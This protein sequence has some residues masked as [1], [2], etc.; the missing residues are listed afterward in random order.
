[1]C[2]HISYVENLI[3][4]ATV[5]RGSIFNRRLGSALMNALMAF[6]IE[7]GSLQKDQFGLSSLSLPCPHH[8]SVA[9]LPS[10]MGCD[11][12]NKLLFIIN[13]RV[14]GILF[15]VAQNRMRQRVIIMCIGIYDQTESNFILFMIFLLVLKAFAINMYYFIKLRK[16]FN[17]E[18]LF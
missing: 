10:T 14:G 11:P 17:F 18:L 4:S 8:F 3:L 7:V 12:I 16:L 9:L 13:Y 6:I 2:S 5:L 15:L 1:M